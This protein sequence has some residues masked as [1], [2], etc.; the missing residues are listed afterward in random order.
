MDR[1]RIYTALNDDVTMLAESGNVFVLLTISCVAAVGAL[2]YLVSIAFWATMLTGS[3]VLILTFLYW[4]VGRS[5]NKY[6]E[7]AR[8]SRNV[9]M[10]L[11]NGMIEGFKEISLRGNKKL[12][13]RRD[14]LQS[15]NEYK[16]KTNKAGVISVNASIV[17]EIVLMGILGVVALGFPKLF[18][19]I[20][21][22]TLLSFVIVLLYL[23]GPV[24]A[25]LGFAP[26]AQRLRIA[27]KRIQDFLNDIPSDTDITKISGPLAPVSTLTVRDVTFR[28]DESSNG[29]FSVGPLNLEIKSGE[30][31]FIIGANGSGK[32]TLAKLLTG[33]YKPCNGEILIDGK[34]VDGR[35]LGERFSTVFTPTYLFEKLYDIDVLARAG[36]INSLLEML[37]LHHKVQVRDRTYST[38]N[39]SGG[40][41][42]RLA[43]L[44][45]YLEDS[46]IY[47]FDEWA[48]D[49]DP[50]Y[51]HFFYRSLLPRMKAQ[52]KIVIAITHDDHYFDAAD[53]ILKMSQGRLECIK[54]DLQPLAQ[55]KLAIV[56]H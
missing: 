8:E 53:K 28:Y 33:L 29:V 40:Q 51:R 27:W 15:A 50:E 2:L 39:L 38:V 43:L 14:V 32:T 47:L 12:E 21:S 24:D 46:P 22:Y 36:Q 49:Q 30:I 25:I 37:D 26:S 56:S 52:G 45:C 55:S 34:V 31:M 20:E 23:L 17:G 13:Y 18:P 6:F 3:L 44:Q 19:E 5:T 42:K 11:I 1:G 16:E 41:R 54:S 10:N 4:L 7:E 35:E 9:F 48:A